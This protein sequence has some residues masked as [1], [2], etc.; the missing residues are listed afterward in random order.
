MSD[1][2]PTQLAVLRQCPEPASGNVAQPESQE[3][4]TTCEELLALGLIQIGRIDLALTI[5]GHGG[6]GAT[7]GDSIRGYQRTT[8]GTSVAS[9]TT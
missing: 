9:P 4:C 8:S 7:V 3:E 2:T 1:L 5:A 6:H